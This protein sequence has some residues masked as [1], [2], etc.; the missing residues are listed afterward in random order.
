MQKSHGDPWHTHR[1]KERVNTKGEQASYRSL[2][3]QRQRGRQATARAGR[4]GDQPP[5]GDTRHTWGCAFAV[6]PGTRAVGTG[7]ANKTFRLPGTVCFPRT[8][9]SELLGP[10]KGT[11]RTIQ[12]S[13]WPC[14]A[15]ESPRG[16]D[17]GSAG[18]CG[19]HLGQ[20]P[21]RAPW[22]PSS[23]DPGSARH[24]GLWQTQHGPPT[25][26]TPHTCQ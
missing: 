11:K 8:Q 23:V 4:Q 19:A 15:R 10:G 7:T 9:P 16:L 3:P 20:C 2:P 13:L 26:H 22:R 12:P 5:R 24:L 6:H 21:C 17:L 18:K 1:T 14:A 25:A